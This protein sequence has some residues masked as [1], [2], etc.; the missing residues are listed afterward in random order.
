MN[1]C[2]LRTTSQAK[3]IVIKTKKEKEGKKEGKKEGDGDGG[4]RRE[5]KKGPEPVRD[6]SRPNINSGSVLLSHNLAVA[7]SSALEGLTAV[8]GMGTGGSPPAWP[9]E[10]RQANFGTPRFSTRR[11]VVRQE[12]GSNFLEQGRRAIQASRPISTGTLKPLRALHPQPI[13]LVVF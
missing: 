11:S 6:G 10:N 13:N 12:E 1:R 8:F 9:P 7:V 3:R 2:C 4:A 5:V